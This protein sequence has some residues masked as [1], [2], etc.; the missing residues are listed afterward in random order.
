M[1][2]LYKNYRLSGLLGCLRSRNFSRTD[3]F[4]PFPAQKR[5]SGIAVEA[6][7]LTP[8][9]TDFAEEANKQTN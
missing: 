8:A 4:L 3:I 9:P 1:S 7:F 5:L 6:L 2:H